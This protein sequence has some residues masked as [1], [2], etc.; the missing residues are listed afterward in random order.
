MIPFLMFIRDFLHY[1]KFRKKLQDGAPLIC[2][3][4]IYTARKMCY[5]N[6]KYGKKRKTMISEEKINVAGIQAV[7]KRRAAL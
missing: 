2:K 1:N 5:N 4:Y 7:G 3:L 6:E